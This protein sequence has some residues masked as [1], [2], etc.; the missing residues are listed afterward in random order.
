[1]SN[2]NLSWIELELELGFDNKVL[3]KKSWLELLTERALENVQ[4]RIFRPLGS[5]E[6]KKKH[7]C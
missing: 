4:D 7:K 1:M 5:R 6:I 2:L 3:T